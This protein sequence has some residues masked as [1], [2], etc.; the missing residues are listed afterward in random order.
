MDLF[1][2]ILKK[3]PHSPLEGVLFMS[4]DKL[5]QIRFNVETKATLTR[6]EKGCQ[7]K[8]ISTKPHKNRN[9]L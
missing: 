9:Q 2:C 8:Q 5:L 1:P 3:Q 4:F 7:S 6:K